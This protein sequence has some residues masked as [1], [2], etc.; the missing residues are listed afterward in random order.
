MLDQ[1][2]DVLW[3]REGD[4]H[5]WADANFLR[6]RWGD[7]FCVERETPHRYIARVVLVHMDEDGHPTME[8][9]GAERRFA[10]DTLHEIGG[11]DSAHES[12]LLAWGDVREGLDKRVE[13]VLQLDQKRTARREKLLKLARRFR[14]DALLEANGAE[15]EAGP[16]AE[17]WRVTVPVSIAQATLRGWVRIHEDTTLVAGKRVL[18][19]EAALMRWGYW[20]HDSGRGCFQDVLHA[21]DY[22]VPA[23]KP[24]DPLLGLGFI[25]DKLGYGI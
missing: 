6:G 7:V 10:K 5:P 16:D 2:V 20:G 19:V 24:L 22:A 25:L 18:R 1:V 13:F 9:S 14:G 11:P 8:L 17:T 12:G 21:D 3:D 4:S 15:I 23:S